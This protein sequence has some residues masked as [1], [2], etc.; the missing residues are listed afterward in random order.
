M[1][2]D[3][4]RAWTASGGEM[5]RVRVVRHVAVRGGIPEERTSIQFHTLRGRMIGRAELAPGTRAGDLDDEALEALLAR[6]R[7]LPRE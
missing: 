3:T 6:A 4:G 2:Q 1:N 5:Y 7:W